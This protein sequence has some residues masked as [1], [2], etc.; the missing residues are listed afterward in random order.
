M[1]F[2]ADFTRANVYD[3]QMYPAITS[4]LPQVEVRYIAADSGY[5]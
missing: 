5:I 2:S 1:P 3:N 4:S